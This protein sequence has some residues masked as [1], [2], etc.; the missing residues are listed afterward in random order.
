MKNANTV[1]YTTVFICGVTGMILEIIGSR[2][3]SPYFGSS[4]YVWTC[5]IGILLASLSAGYYLGGKYADSNADYRQLST[6]ILLASFFVWITASFNEVFLDFLTSR[7]T[8]LRF[9][10]TVSILLLF[11]PANVFLGMV[12]PYTVRLSLRSLKSTG[13]ITGRIYAI[14]TVG[15]IIGT[16]LSGYVLIAIIGHRE[17]LFLTSLILLSVS[18]LLS[19]K[20]LIIL[21]LFF[22]AVVALQIISYR[23]SFLHKYTGDV[24]IDTQY[25]NVRISVK[26]YNGRKVMYLYSNRGKQSAVF[27]DSDELVLAYLKYFKL[28]GYFNKNIH[29]TLMIGGGGYSFPQ[30]FLRQNP[31]VLMDVVEI[32]PGITEIAKKYFHLHDDD[33]LRIY[34][35][36]GRVFINKTANNYDAIFMDAFFHS[37]PP[38]QMVTE[39]AVKGIHRILNADGVVLVNIVASLDG[40]G[41]MLFKSIYKTYRSVFK[42]V[43]VFPVNTM[44]KSEKQNI[45]LVALKTDNVPVF[46]YSDDDYGEYLSHLWKEFIITENSVNLIDDFAPVENLSSGG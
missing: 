40:E 33:R 23:N 16:F 17:I 27:A 46:D 44:D 29:K 21:K 28:A 12:T 41:S 32:D 3:L 9:S 8:G 22:A 37:T 38:F 5:L 34:H 2:V 15:S 13:S 39:E 11:S 25:Q 35:E 45:M 30:Y 24:S 10:V 43:Y 18:I 20:K 42:N 4:I 31:Y 1:L 26:E 36:D 14:S 6:F 19:P 7:E